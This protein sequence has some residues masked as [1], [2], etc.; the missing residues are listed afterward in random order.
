MVPRLPFILEFLIS[1]CVLCVCACV[2]LCESVGVD[3][4]CALHIS[5]VR[6]VYEVSLMVWITHGRIA[7]IVPR[8]CAPIQG[9][10]L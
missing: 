2:R 5:D 4:N 8:R 6:C 9:D 10:A 7:N 3:V 1:L